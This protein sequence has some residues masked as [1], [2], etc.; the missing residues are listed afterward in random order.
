MIA[1]AAA[2]LL[3]VLMVSACGSSTDNSS[4]SGIELL[5]L[6]AEQGFQRADRPRRFSFPRDH[7]V[8]KGFRTEWWYLTGHLSAGQRQFGYQVTFFRYVIDPA[9]DTTGGWSAD[10]VWLAQVALSDI[11]NAAFLT[12][13]QLSREVEG[14]SGA[15]TAGL[16][17]SV[18]GWRLYQTVKRA[19]EA[20]EYSLQ[21]DADDF[22]LTLNL[23]PDKPLVLQGEE[24]WS[25]KSADDPDNASYYYSQTRLA[26]N[27]TVQLDGEQ[28]Q[29]SGSSWFDREWSTSALHARQAGWDWF[30][31]QLDNQ[32]ELMFYQLR[33]QDG[34]ID[35]AS[36]GVWVSPE[37]EVKRLA[38]ADVQLEATRYW[39]SPHSGTRYPVSWRMDVPD[40]GL[41]LR[42]QAVMPNQL[43]RG[44]LS[45]WEGAMI[46]SGTLSSTPVT[47]RAYV[48][49]TGY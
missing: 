46:V 25:R 15:S 28:L 9:E 26:A 5:A 32:H 30:A 12:S 48:E 38:F 29:V 3:V 37:G 8:H 14:I 4:Q 22:S 36:T 16:D 19:E 27:G 6:P 44:R 17:V 39:Q 18:Q 2:V 13:E 34:G 49:L 10:A 21:I 40:L 11:E 23:R 24:G 41:Q 33:L 47:G 7:G 42:L 43:W 45:Y 31:V 35:R 20:G 1:R